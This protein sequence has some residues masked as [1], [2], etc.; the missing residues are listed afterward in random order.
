[1][2]VD[3]HV[4]LY[5]SPERGAQAKGRPDPPFGT[6]AELRA[7]LDSELD[8][9]V[10]ANFLPAKI[11]REQAGTDDAELWTRQARQNAWAL[12]VARDDPRLRVLVG[13][14]LPLPDA[15]LEQLD[16]WLGAPECCGIKLHPSAGDYRADDPRLADLT[17]LAA[18][19]DK[20]IM[21]HAGPFAPAHRSVGVPE[22]CALAESVPGRLVVAH[23]GGAD[24]RGALAIAAAGERV[25]LDTSAIL[26]SSPQ[27]EAAALLAAV[28][29]ELGDERLIHGS[30][31]PFFDYDEALLRLRAVLPS[32]VAADR[33]LGSNAAAAYAIST[34]ATLPSRGTE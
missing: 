34:I 16:G 19:H 22:L 32:D 28:V 29:R 2:I 18:R 27:A 5:P 17:A 6:L 10:V 11:M 9:A 7:A 14:L 26:T 25:W 24:A 13:A 3:A 21:V 31:A 12:E 8:G 15:A 20:A 30:D 4:H 1:V 33:I 23:L